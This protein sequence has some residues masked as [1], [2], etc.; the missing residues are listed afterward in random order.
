MK[1]NALKMFVVL[2]LLFSISYAI[3]ADADLEPPTITVEDLD[4]WEDGEVELLFTI[5]DT[6]SSGLKEAKYCISDTLCDTEKGILIEEEAILISDE[7]IHVVYFQA[8][9]FAGNASTLGSTTVKIDGIAP[10]MSILGV[11][12]GWYNHTITAN[13]ACDDEVS[14]CFKNSFM[15]YLSPIGE[16]VCEHDLN[17]YTLG[18]TT[19]VNA[20][21]LICVYGEDVVG[22][23][24]F[25]PDP[26]I[27][28]FD[29]NN[30]EAED[31]NVQGDWENVDFAMNIICNDNEESGCAETLLNVVSYG[32]ECVA[33]EATSTHLISSHSTTCWQSTDVAG[34]IFNDSVIIYVDKINPKIQLI[35]PATTTWQNSSFDLD[36]VDTDS[37]G[38]QIDFCEYKVESGFEGSQILTR[39]WTNRTCSSSVEIVVGVDEDCRIE[40]ENVCKITLRNR[41]IAQ[42]ITTLELSYLISLTNPVINYSVLGA[43]TNGW[44]NIDPTIRFTVESINS[45][46]DKIFY[47][48]GDVGDYN[49]ELCSGFECQKD[50]VITNGIHEIY[51]Y[52]IDVAENESNRDTVE[53][54]VDSIDPVV[55]AGLDKEVMVL[56]TQN[57]TST[58]TLSGIDNYLWSQV[59]GPA[60][61]VVAFDDM[62]VL[63]PEVSANL[64]G[65]YVLRLTVN[66]IAGNSFFDEM[67]LAWGVEGS[68]ESPRSSSGSSGYYLLKKQNQLPIDNHST[69]TMASSTKE[70]GGDE[71]DE[72]DEFFEEGGVAEKVYKNIK[73]I[74]LFLDEVKVI[75]SGD[76]GMF[77][78]NAGVKLNKALENKYYQ[79][80]KN[81]LESVSNFENVNIYSINNFITYG[82]YS[83][84]GLGVGERIGVLK[85]YQFA[86]KK[87]PST[88]SDWFDV[89]KISNGYWP[90]EVDTLAEVVAR[91]KF[92]SV[93]LRE[94]VDGN[95]QDKSAVMLTAYGV[96]PLK[97]SIADE[98][99]AIEIFENIFKKSPIE[100]VDWNV[101]RAIAYSGA[102]R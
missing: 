62:S 59:S 53:I 33:T 71:G 31:F 28:R 40:G 24:N 47:R 45:E 10:N 65:V 69:L 89:L 36:I 57:A 77:T 83:T 70:S 8:W 61:G 18:T 93:Y 64:E 22:N 11:S 67:N 82:T 68:N 76:A 101:V 94:S 84:K 79:V 72:V 74:D 7:G 16:G 55:D 49:E 100:V 34:N 20:D 21:A 78:M 44:Y 81:L 66:D 32:E 43:L 51:Y 41:D 99:K 50:V 37:G 29:Y 52:T 85:S 30:P 5:E 26:I 60:G 38:A 58:D 102:S 87:L 56:F 4:D 14:G 1:K 88:E 27:V 9:D 2:F 98:L 96:R 6:G 42:N 35:T 46:I 90:S 39:D 54:N 63:S 97:R 13:I 19:E 75:M 73:V 15:Y 12:A 80:T 95:L 48:D 86:Y 3:A 23:G 17:L 92:E 25:A 91:Y